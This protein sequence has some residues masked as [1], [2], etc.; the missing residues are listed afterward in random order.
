MENKYKLITI[1]TVSIISLL[2]AYTYLF[3]YKKLSEF[4]GQQTEE[5]LICS[6]KHFLKDNVN[7]LI[8]EIDTKRKGKTDY[9][10]KVG[11]KI[12]RNLS[13]QDNLTDEEF[14]D[15]FKLQF[16]SDATPSLFSHLLWDKTSDEII[17]KSDGLDTPLDDI[18]DRLSSYHIIHHG[19]VGG[20]FGV[21]KDHI[22]NNVKIEMEERIKNMRFEDGSYVWVNEVINYEGGDDYAIR[23]I[24]PNL[25]ET[26]G[27]YLSTNTKDIK[28]NFPYLE[29]LEG[30][31]SKGELF[32][33]Y[34]FKRL[35]SDVIDEK[36]SYAKL[37]EDYNW[38]IAMGV[39]TEDIRECKTRIEGKTQSLMSGYTLKFMA[40]IIVLLLAGN[41]ILVTLEKERHR[42]TRK[43]LECE[44]NE[45]I[46]TGAASRRRGIQE[47]QMVFKKYKRGKT[48]TAIM[49][50]DLDDFKSVND[51][52]GHDF[53]DYVLVSIV[54]AV[55]KNI[56]NSDTIIRWGG[57]EFIC[58]LKDLEVE[59]SIKVSS[60]IL[61][62]VSSLKLE[63][64]GYIMSPTVS[65][66]ISYFKE[67]DKDFNDVIMRAD[68]V[69]YESKTAGKNKV[70]LKI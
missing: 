12:Y 60:K 22:D 52:Y 4:Y 43:N 63:K 15:F 24:H 1:V 46:L 53:G 34:Y 50:F 56:R 14:I 58:I 13:S 26:E 48:N 69:L 54:D 5:I 10:Q 23:R 27:E 3:T 62:A 19:N 42:F 67:T 66:G 17:Y 57:D 44:V 70:S 36:L 6:K 61:Q 25:V 45:D 35:N 51:T 21:A 16:E 7:N 68:N 20:I 55:Y 29:E 39:H 65:A 31:K 2:V 38:I 28:G 59:D 49:L 32:F 64:D 11:D 18:R 30:I 37:Y 47:L 33:T 40:F 41:F 8:I 9:Y